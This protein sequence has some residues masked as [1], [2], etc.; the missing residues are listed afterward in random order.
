MVQ[1]TKIKLSEKQD[2]STFTSFVLEGG[3]ELLQSQNNGKFYAKGKKALLNT[4]LSEDAAKAMIGT[5]LPGSIQRVPCEPY[6]YTVKETGEVVTLF[7]TY[8]YSPME[9]ATIT[10]TNNQFAVDNVEDM[11]FERV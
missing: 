4:T 7:H 2:G 11:P 8:E 6:E 10:K 1:I 3:I 9:E 5:S